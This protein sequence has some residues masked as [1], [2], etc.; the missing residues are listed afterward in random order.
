[1]NKSI[2]WPKYAV[3]AI[4]FFIMFTHCS[5]PT[6]DEI[7]TTET[8]SWNQVPEPKPGEFI[9]STNLEFHKISWQYFLWLT[10]EVGN[11]NLRFE[12]MFND[13]SINLEANDPNGRSHILGGIQQ[14]GS[15]SILVD[16]NGRAI[17][18]SMMIDSI[19]RNFVVDNNLNTPEGLEEIPDTTD[20]RIGSMSLK[21]AWKIIPDGQSA[22]KGAYTRKA[23]LY[24]VVKIDRNLTTSDN[25][26]DKTKRETIEETVALVGFHI[27]VVVKDHPEFIW[28]TFEH[29]DNAINYILKNE[30]GRTGYTFF[31]KANFNI[32]NQGALDVDPKSQK[33]TYSNDDDAT[34]Q[35][36]RRHQFGGGSSKNQNNIDS[37][38]HIVHDNLP[39]NSIWKNYHEVGAVWFN[40]GNG[41]HPNW[42][43]TVADSIVTGSL[44]LSNSVIE[45]F[46][47]DPFQQNSCFSC[48]N[49]SGYNPISGPSIAGKNVLTSHI[50]LKNYINA[51]DKSSTIKTVDR[52]K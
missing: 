49:S 43:P 40:I 20:F 6:D 24:K 18:T 44:T 47:Q 45:T 12:T 27:A 39:E 31:N 52:S 10:E 46:T 33:I 9:D 29:N 2:H 28:A 21:A 51:I 48:H 7:T 34:T 11:G 50:L 19:Y 23:A 8:F 4:C 36:Y 17:Y 35:V 16:K 13:A 22:P 42:S 5:E 15:N 1:M 37:L 26:K 3:F 41:L 38:N 14:A 25:Y 32:R 30:T